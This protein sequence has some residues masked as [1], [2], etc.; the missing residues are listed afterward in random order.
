MLAISVPPVLVTRTTELRLLSMYRRRLSQEHRAVSQIYRRDDSFSDSAQAEQSDKTVVEL[1]LSRP[2]HRSLHGTVLRY[3]GP[4][5]P[6][7]EDEWEA[8]K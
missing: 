2:S 6:I 5:E 1:L 7:A 3:D 4:L 8:S